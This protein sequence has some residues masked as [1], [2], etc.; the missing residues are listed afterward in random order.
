MMERSY[1]PTKKCGCLFE[2]PKCAI[3][4]YPFIRQINPRPAPSGT[5]LC[6][7]WHG[8]PA[9]CARIVS[10]TGGMMA[11][12]VSGVRADSLATRS[13]RQTQPTETFM[14]T[15]CMLLHK[16]SELWHLHFSSAS[17]GASGW[18]RG[19]WFSSVDLEGHEKRQFLCSLNRLY[20]MCVCVVDCF[21]SL[22]HYVALTSYL[23]IPKWCEIIRWTTLKNRN[24]SYA[25]SWLSK[26]HLHWWN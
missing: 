9:I 16:Q 23:T 2:S 3:S 1:A 14:E 20:F 17:S 5:A 11:K 21:V 25:A 22:F 10:G 12:A 6:G 26:C 13:N 15:E 7:I 24:S 18:K 4:P 8:M 19:Q